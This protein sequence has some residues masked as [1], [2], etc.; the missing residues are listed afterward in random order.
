VTRVKGKRPPLRNVPPTPQLPQVEA[1]P[2]DRR[3]VYGA[4][5]SWWGSI[6]EVGSIGSGLPCCPT[7]SGVLFEVPSAQEWWAG[8]DR[9]EAEGR[10]GYRAFIEWLRGRCFPSLDAAWNEWAAMQEVKP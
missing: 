8:V 9:H 1:A 6:S 4:R 2:L 5:C 3:V 10:T 7:C